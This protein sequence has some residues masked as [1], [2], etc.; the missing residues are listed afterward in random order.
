M[1]E[2]VPHSFSSIRRMD[3]LV[4]RSSAMC[5][6]STAPCRPGFTTASQLSY[7]CGLQ[8][9]CAKCFW[10]F[11]TLTAA[12]VWKKLVE[13]MED[14]CSPWRRGFD[15]KHQVE[16]KLN[17][18]GQQRGEYVS[19]QFAKY[20]V[21]LKNKIKMSHL[22]SCRGLKSMISVR[23]SA[24]QMCCGTMFNWGQT[25]THAACVGRTTPLS[26]LAGGLPLRC[27]IL[28]WLPS[29]NNVPLI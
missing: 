23:N 25:C 21:S 4:D 28:D 24:S 1:N 2:N 10:H 7:A 13:S 18:L 15:H 12:S 11:A 3:L 14:D 19:G 20:Y 9:C 8:M 29:K 16:S 27:V 22:I 5:Y 6:S 26:L 17:R